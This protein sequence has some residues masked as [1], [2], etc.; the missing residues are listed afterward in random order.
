MPT[1]VIIILGVIFFVYWSATS[2]VQNR[3]EELNVNFITF[4]I[5]KCGLF[6]FLTIMK[7]YLSMKTGF[8][9]SEIQNVSRYIVSFYLFM[10]LI[11]TFGIFYFIETNDADAVLNNGW[12]GL[13]L[14]PHFLSSI[15][16]LCYFL[17]LKD[18]FSLYINEEIEKDSEIISLKL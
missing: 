6:T 4:V 17:F 14:Y 16:M 5:F 13:I 2:Y 8:L 1:K 9:L 10:G 7:L 3:A 12:R 11:V 18:R 15:F